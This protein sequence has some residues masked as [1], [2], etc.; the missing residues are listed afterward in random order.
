MLHGK[1]DSSTLSTQTGANATN[2]AG[3]SNATTSTKAV[4]LIYFTNSTAKNILNNNS[5]VSEQT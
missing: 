5:D 1:I 2:C 4:D 3:F